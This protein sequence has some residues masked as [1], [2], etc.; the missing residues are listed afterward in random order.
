MGRKRGLDD[1]TAE[2]NHWCADQLTE[3]QLRF[4]NNLPE[5]DFEH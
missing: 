5:N 1:F 3:E 4:L 2:L